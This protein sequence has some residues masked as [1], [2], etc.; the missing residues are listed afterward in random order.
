MCVCFSGTASTH[1]VLVHTIFS[2]VVE[3]NIL[4]GTIHQLHHWLFG[5]VGGG[6]GTTRLPWKHEVKG[7]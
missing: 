4:Q 3:D 2:F 5:F 1:V 6:L 7:V